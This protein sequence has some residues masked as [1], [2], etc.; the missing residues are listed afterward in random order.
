VKRFWLFGG[1]VCYPLGGMSDF[2]KDMNSLEMAG[3]VGRARARKGIKYLDGEEELADGEV[4]VQ[5]WHVY[6]SQTGKIAARSDV[7][8]HGV[9]DP[10]TMF[11]EK[12]R[13]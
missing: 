5:W 8:P 2:L 4:L 10:S 1:E 13:P 6:D 9:Y 3:A 12:V 7:L 11:P